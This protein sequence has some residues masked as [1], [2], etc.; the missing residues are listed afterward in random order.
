MISFGFCHNPLVFFE[1]SIVQL[2]DRSPYFSNKAIENDLFGTL[3][4]RNPNPKSAGRQNQVGHSHDV[5]LLVVD[6][7]HPA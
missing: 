1:F 7:Q 6:G 2:M 3:N 4:V 5:N